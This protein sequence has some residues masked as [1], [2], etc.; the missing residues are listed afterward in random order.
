MKSRSKQTK[1]YLSRSKEDILI[2]ILM[3]NNNVIVVSMR[4]R[5]IHLILRL[6]PF[7]FFFF[8]F[9]SRFRG[10][11]FENPC[12][13]FAQTGEVGWLWRKKSIKIHL[14]GALV[15]ERGPPAS[16]FR[17][18][19][20]FS[21]NFPRTASRFVSRRSPFH[22]RV[23]SRCPFIALALHPSFIVLCRDRCTKATRRWN[24]LFF[25]VETPRT[26]ILARANSPVLRNNLRERA[27]MLS[28]HFT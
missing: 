25:I 14:V 6:P 15:N 27:P 16:P 26:N 13:A 23:R 4:R 1:C 11:K 19:L 22:A 17:N 18:K 8:F 21:K 3:K 24:S 28:A 5:F 12:H 2:S 7:F 10:W 20:A 9:Y